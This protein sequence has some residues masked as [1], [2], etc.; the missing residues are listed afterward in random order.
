[1][2]PQFEKSQEIEDIVISLMEGRADL[3]GGLFQFIFPEM[4]TCGIRIDKPA[5]PNQ[6]WILKIV[7]VK[8]QFTLL[9]D[10]KYIIYGYQTSWDKLS[11]EKKVAH[12]ASMLKHIDYPTEEE[13][14]AL[15]EKGKDYQYGKLRKPDIT[16][17]RTFLVAPGFG[18]GW[19]EEGNTIPNLLEKKEVLI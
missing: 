14:N 19:E 9:T 10:K 17:W 7:G 5:P 15:A 4:I 16:D 13:M 11:Y 1:M 2:A 8:G 12:V 3:F 6:K 18:V